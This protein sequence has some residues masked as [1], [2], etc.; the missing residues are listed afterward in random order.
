MEKNKEKVLVVSTD[1]VKDMLIESGLLIKKAVDLIEVIRENC[2]FIDRGYAEQCVDIKQIIPYVI[3]KNDNNI[4]LLRR[5]NRQT[6]KRLH[7]KL[8]IGI[9]GHINIDSE[10]HKDIIAHGLLK[11]LN[12]EV[13]VEHIESIDFVGVINDDS[14]DVGVHHL[15]LMYVLST[16]SDVTVLEKDKMS[17]EWVNINRAVALNEMMETWSQISL[18][19]LMT[20]SHE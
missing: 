20:A 18:K 9:G 5:L 6:E 8:S 3:I 19:Y 12:E 13:Q 2:Y 14:T 7:G 16:S 4:F 10:K 17:G 11:E 15:G 1:T